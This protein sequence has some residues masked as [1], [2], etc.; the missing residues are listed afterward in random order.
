[1][2]PPCSNSQSAQIS[3]PHYY[4]THL[5][6]ARIFKCPVYIAEEDEE[7]TV[8]ANVDGL[9]HHIT[10]GTKTIVPG[11]TAIKCGGHFPGS[12]VLHWE[13]KMFHADTFKA[14]PVSCKA[15]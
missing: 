5:T 15:A 8:R 12:L 6:W 9:R 7:W 14:I 2:R 13:N 10:S 1:M 11:V 4:T 3:H